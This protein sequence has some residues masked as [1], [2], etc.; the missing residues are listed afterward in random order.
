MNYAVTIRF[1]AD[2]EQYA[3]SPLASLRGTDQADGWVVR[4]DDGVLSARSG[5]NSHVNARLPWF[6]G[7]HVVEWR[8]VDYRHEL[9]FD[10]IP[11]TETSAD[12]VLGSANILGV[13]EDPQMPGH[14]YSGVQEVT[15]G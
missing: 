12:L 7:E 6:D 10:G 9:W 15:L 3:C 11:V 5:D 13:G 1:V 2:G 8:V 14:V 4:I